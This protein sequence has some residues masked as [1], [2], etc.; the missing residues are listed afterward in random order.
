MVWITAVVDH[1]CL[2]RLGRARGIDICSG[3]VALFVLFSG[4][5][6]AQSPPK[7]K[8]GLESFLIS[9]DTKE[10]QTYQLRHPASEGPQ[11][12]TIEGTGLPVIVEDVPWSA[13]RTAISVTDNTGV[14]IEFRIEN[15]SLSL[16]AETPDDSL[17][18]FQASPDL[19]HWFR[20]SSSDSGNDAVDARFQETS[21][22][23]AIELEP[24]PGTNP[25]GD[26][27]GFF[28]LTENGTQLVN[29]SV[30]DPP[31]NS[32]PA[33]GAIGEIVGTTLSGIADDEGRLILR[34]APVGS[35]LFRVSKEDLS[36]EV[37]LLVQSLSDDINVVGSPATSRPTVIERIR[38]EVVENLANPGT[39]FVYGVLDPLPAGTVIS[40]P[41][42]FGLD[43]ALV[44][45]PLF[46]PSW[47]FVIDEH[48]TQGFGHAV[49]F[50]IVDDES[51]EM[52]VETRY[53]NPEINGLEPWGAL[54]EVPEPY[55][56]Q[57]PTEEPELFEL[58]QATPDA[59][60]VASV[61]AQ[62]NR[63]ALVRR[64]M[65]AP[66]SRPLVFAIFIVGGLEAPFAEAM[67][68]VKA[69][70]KPDFSHVFQA[71]R[72]DDLFSKRTK[73]KGKVIPKITF[74]YQDML[75]IFFS[76]MEPHDTLFIYVN[77]HHTVKGGRKKG[78]AVL[79]KTTLDGEIS[80]GRASSGSRIGNEAEITM[81]KLAKPLAKLPSCNL[82]MFLDSCFSGALLRGAPG[83]GIS[84]DEGLIEN[85]KSTVPKAATILALSAANT[86]MAAKYT[87]NFRFIGSLVKKS[88]IGSDA[89]NQMIQ[90]GVFPKGLDQVAMAKAFGTAL[91]TTGTPMFEQGADIW[92]RP[93]APAAICGKPILQEEEEPNDK[94][95]QANI[96]T[97]NEDGD[98]GSVGSI[99]DETDRDTY[100]ISLPEDSYLFTVD[101]IINEMIVELEDGRQINEGNQA[102]VQLEFPQTV[103]VSVSGQ[104][105]GTYVF[106]V[107]QFTAKTGVRFV[108]TTDQWIAFRIV[109]NEV[110]ANE[111]RV[112]RLE[113]G[114]SY[115]ERFAT[116]LTGLNMVDLHSISGAIPIGSDGNQGFDI[117]IREG[118][119]WVFRFGFPADE[120]FTET[121]D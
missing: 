3:L 40:T 81:A 64:S 6:V 121:L 60:V 42:P 105:R 21:F 118:L 62:T 69:A 115:S 14:A 94:K 116:T 7:L 5:G 25:T 120:F 54:G 43:P 34:G 108:N 113:P 38:K 33:S 11:T 75:D 46:S 88:S 78:N 37:P 96:L 91:T 41:D 66:G 82:V 45:I 59:A 86:R 92:I 32:S 61:G 30:F 68:K 1:M 8:L 23:R 73:I 35:Q 12:I 119:R 72:G 13:N 98:I 20:I 67:K 39:A 89:G 85:L 70:I 112:I 79:G 99:L 100:L 22:F 15:Q 103:T 24:E 9:F 114:D 28:Y 51:G 97:P 47:F 77:G 87:R 104:G 83:F 111:G 57:T 80:Y 93:G 84:K 110:V 29:G 95:E 31:A 58:P 109:A 44:G 65:H 90:G 106:D 74:P 101:D 102:Y 4:M 18:E 55:I 76:Q 2:G 19:D 63:G 49:T 10:G 52:R 16:N 17:F 107:N 36:I 56:V 117:S 48:S 53:G 27:V 71:N 50:V 26:V